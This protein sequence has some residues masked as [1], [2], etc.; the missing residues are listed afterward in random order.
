MGAP[1]NVGTTPAPSE[2]LHLAHALTREERCLARDAPAIP[3]EASVATHDAMARDQDG[4]TIA[5]TRPRDCT[6]RR[7]PAQPRGDRL[8]R[9]CRAFGDALQRAPHLPLEGRR[10]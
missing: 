3:A 5:R 4:H 6:R 7:G 8:V 10:A 2:E 9:T 1:A